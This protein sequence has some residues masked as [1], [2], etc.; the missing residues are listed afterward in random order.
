VN[1]LNNNFMTPKALSREFKVPKNFFKNLD[2]KITVPTI[3]CSCGEEVLD[4]LTNRLQ[5]ELTKENK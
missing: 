1:K 2:Y 3:I 5:S 4:T